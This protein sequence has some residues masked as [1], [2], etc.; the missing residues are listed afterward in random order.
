MYRIQRVFLGLLITGSMAVQASAHYRVLAQVAKPSLLSRLFATFPK[1]ASLSVVKAAKAVPS[2]VWHNRYPLGGILIAVALYKFLCWMDEDVGP[3]DVG[4]QVQE[5][6]VKAR[7]EV[8]DLKKLL[9]TT[10]LAA[11]QAPLITKQKERLV[12][13]QADIDLFNEGIALLNDLKKTNIA[14]QAEKEAEKMFVELHKMVDLFIH[15][16]KTTVERSA[17]LQESSPD[18]SMLFNSRIAPARF[19][20]TSSAYVQQ[21]LER[22][23]RCV[24]CLR[25]Y[26]DCIEQN[27]PVHVQHKT[28][29]ERE[30][31]SKLVQ[32]RVAKLREVAAKIELLRARSAELQKL[33]A[34]EEAQLK[35][36]QQVRPAEQQAQKQAETLVGGAGKEQK[37]E[38][39]Q[40]VEQTAAQE[41]EEPYVLRVSDTVRIAF[42]IPATQT[43]SP[44][45]EI[46]EYEQGTWKKVS[47]NIP[48][49]VVADPQSSGARVLAYLEDKGYVHRSNGKCA[50]D[51]VRIRGYLDGKR[52]CADKHLQL[53]KRSK[54]QVVDDREEMEAA[55]K[56]A[57]SFEG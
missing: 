33:L 47:C 39:Q 30:Q 44:F 43:V 17:K 3:Q 14:P 28:A 34:E 15:G 51:F 53:P 42:P 40:T 5:K 26:A 37:A 10:P 22:V 31:V 9:D 6:I 23:T 12:L 11:T 24:V 35:A 8:D 4:A 21:L 25:G 18:I 52:G 46:F 45:V 57:R 56:R 19:G 27:L 13:V 32:E 55:Q 2:L 50:I 38:A 48:D 29:Q 54:E 41:V 49:L 20:Q 16:T 7:A 36:T 1:K